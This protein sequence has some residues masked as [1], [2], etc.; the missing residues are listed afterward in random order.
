MDPSPINP[1]ILRL[2]PLDIALSRL[3][4]LTPP[5]GP[6]D[7]PLIQA[8]GAVLARDVHAPV[9]LPV[10]P[11]AHADGWLVKAEDVQG[12]SA[13]SAAMLTPPPD[14][15]DAGDPV[16]GG[17]AVLPPEAVSIAA[18][19]VAEATASATHGDGVRA[20]GE[21]ISAGALILS[22]GTR[23]TP[24]HLGLL[25]ACGLA[26][27]PVRS[28]KVRL[29][30]AN[31]AL[32]AHSD[33][34]GLWL[35]A[36]GAQLTDIAVMPAGSAALAACFARADADLVVS[37]GGT[38]QGRNDCAVAAL[39][40]AGSVGLYGLALNPGSSAAFGH[41]ASMPVILVP[42]RIDAM[43][44]VL[45]LLVGPPLAAAARAEP[46]AASTPFRLTEKVTST[47]GF[48]ELF[49]GVASGSEIRPVPLAG[50]NFDAIARAVGWFVVPPSSEGIAAGDTVQ[51]RSF[52]TK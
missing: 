16:Q 21:D 12:S 13:Y 7:R 20:A 44:A 5:A 46:L 6:I 50:A 25:T 48:D 24:R 30:I 4:A 42:G 34:V 52:E 26:S 29:I 31:A 41:V 18:P 43:I 14:W 47:V 40:E 11:T 17:N 10:Q 8:L 27:I 38:G 1:R 51:L 32:A 23:L 19:G 36:A 2:T 3:A 49:L 37:V 35:E 39:A 45:L 33:W 9:A 28:P 22:A 15:V